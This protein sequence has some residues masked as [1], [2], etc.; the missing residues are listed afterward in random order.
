M[1]DNEEGYSKGLAV[2]PAD[3]AAQAV[4]LAWKLAVV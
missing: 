4:L 2:H 1:V 3:W